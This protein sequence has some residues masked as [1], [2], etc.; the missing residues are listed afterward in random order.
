MVVYFQ[1]PELSSVSSLPPEVYVY[2]RELVNP[3]TIIRSKRLGKHQ[4]NLFVYQGINPNPFSGDNPSPSNSIKMII[5][6]SDAIHI[7]PIRTQKKF[8]RRGRIGPAGYL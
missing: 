2:P 8:S 5:Q 7:I 3:F 4:F 1:L 6:K